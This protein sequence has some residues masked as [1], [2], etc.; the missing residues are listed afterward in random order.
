MF[1][2]EEGLQQRLLILGKLNELMKR[3][4]LQV[5]LEKVWEMVNGEAEVLNGLLLL[6]KA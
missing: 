6:G 4:V 5:S 3:W 1:D 2:T